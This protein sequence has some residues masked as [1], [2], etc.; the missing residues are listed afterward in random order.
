MSGSRMKGSRCAGWQAP[1]VP[2]QA[3]IAAR[4][5]EAGFAGRGGVK[6]LAA[7]RVVMY[8][9]KNIVIVGPLLQTPGL[10]WAGWAAAL[11][12]AHA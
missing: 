4:R 3:Q 10:M 2:W 12:T 5:L 8:N 7:L 11:S 6:Q 1:Q 9:S